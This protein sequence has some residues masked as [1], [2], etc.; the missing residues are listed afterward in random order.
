MSD[1]SGTPP[2]DDMDRDHQLEAV[3][4]DWQGKP[5]SAFR[6]TR[7]LA[8]LPE[9]ARRALEEGQHTRKHNFA[10]NVRCAK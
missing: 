3:I 7:G 9:S 1:S 6:S 2:D 5:E 10:A 4:A 8:M